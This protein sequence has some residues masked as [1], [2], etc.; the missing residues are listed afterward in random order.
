MVT[1]GIAR[2]DFWFVSV[3][4]KL[5]QN[6]FIYFDATS[7]KYSIIGLPGSGFFTTLDFTL[8]FLTKYYS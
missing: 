1:I 4:G 2:E 7:Q 5:L 6:V 8:V 3:D